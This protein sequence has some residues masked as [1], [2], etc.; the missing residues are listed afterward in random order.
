VTVLIYLIEYYIKVMNL[1][2]TPSY[3]TPARTGVRKSL[4]RLD[5]RSCPIHAGSPEGQRKISRKK[6]TTRAREEEQG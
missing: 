5:S 1:K 2:M 6:F 3:V 4:Q